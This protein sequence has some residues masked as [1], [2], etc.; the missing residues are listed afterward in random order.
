MS[1]VSLFENI[2]YVGIAL[3]SIKSL[4]VNRLSMKY[5]ILNGVCQ[6]N[7]IF[8]SVSVKCIVTLKM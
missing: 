4:G 3:Q 1:P 6:M 2:R 5:S 8:E 7:V